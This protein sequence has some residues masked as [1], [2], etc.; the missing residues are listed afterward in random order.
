MKK[1]K[2]YIKVDKVRFEW[3]RIDKVRWR[4]IRVNKKD[5]GR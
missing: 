2:V 5:K 4:E 3:V 1:D